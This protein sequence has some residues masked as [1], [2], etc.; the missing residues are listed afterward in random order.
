MQELTFKAPAK[1]NLYLKV[2]KRREDGYHEIETVMQKIDLYDIISLKEKE[3]GVEIFSESKEIPVD[4]SNLCFQVA[5]LLIKEF[6]VRRGVQI[7]I[8]KRIPV[9]AGLG[10]GSSDAGCVFWGL[11]SLWNLRMTE[12]ELI[13]RASKI[14]AD[15]PF[16]VSSFSIAKCRGK[17]EKLSPFF[18]AGDLFY[19]LVV[20]NFPLSSK[21]VYQAYDGIREYKR[22][23]ERNDLERVVM[24]RFPLLSE[25]KQEFRKLK[26]EGVL[27][28]SGPAMFGEF[29]NRKEVMEA[30]RKFER[31][32]RVYICQP[33][34][35]DI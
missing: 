2:L 14:G 16:F 9:C 19:L 5:N 13:E 10:G 3:E 12:Q 33:V 30:K 8:Q 32:G 29:R 21:E 1:I 20:P 22:K 27:S 23:G 15:V 25:I 6:R 4:E 34:K 11:N 31:F 26:V 7:S 35:Q 28:G 18:C 24:E 17:G